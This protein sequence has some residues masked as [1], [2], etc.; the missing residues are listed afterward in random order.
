MRI[1]RPSKKTV[2]PR[3]ASKPGAQLLDPRA[4][5]SAVG[6]RAI[7]QELRGEG[8]PLP[9]STRARMEGEL[10]G[11]F[12]DVR[13]HTGPEAGQQARAEG[14][15][16]FTTGTDIVF[17]RGEYRPGTPYGDALIAH[18]LAHVMQ[19]RGATTAGHESTALEADASKAAARTLGGMF[20][21]LRTRLAGLGPVLRSGLTVQRCSCGG[22]QK[23]GAKTAPA[24]AAG[25]AK[26]DDKAVKTQGAPAD[27][28]VGEK[29][30]LSKA[31]GFSRVADGDVKWTAAELA[32]AKRLLGKIPPDAKAAIQGVALIRVGTPN[33]PGGDP[34]GCFRASV[35]ST[36]GEREDVIELGNGAFSN[37]KDF[38]EPEKGKGKSEVKSY[39]TDAS[40]AKINSL[41][42]EDVLAH[43]IGHAV[44]SAAQREAEAERFKAD[45]AVTPKHDA[46]SK[47]AGR[48][49]NPPVAG[50]SNA[51]AAEL[52]YHGK[53]IVTNKAIESVVDEVQKVS[54]EVSAKK[55]AESAKSIK[56]LKPGVQKAIAL[57]KAAKAKLPAG[58]S[59]PQTS[60]ESGQDAAL[61]AIDDIVKA[62]E[63]KVE[64]QKELEK[65]EKAEAAS[66]GKVPGS[67]GKVDTSR[68]LAEI[69]AIVRLKKIDVK[70]S[71]AIGKYP[72]DNWPDHPEELYADLFQMSI[73]EPGGLK[74]FDPDIAAYFEQPIGIKNAGLKK[75]VDEWVEKQK[76]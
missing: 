17:D 37:D 10:G 47:L 1:R 9:A 3:A 14:A 33:C 6:N 65:G 30:A 12:K 13:I 7:E 46:L 28:L 61:A 71:D 72:K 36:T 51:V 55:L 75:R 73:S 11:S 4:L 58:S 67:V 27:P 18:E 43:E 22:A 52:T 69:V 54:G 59:A 40:G 25:K 53:L 29:A 48:F 20:S 8:Q 23:A 39:R 5:S 41:P 24:K 26:S 70:N 19:Q 63:A 62:I 34:A 45:L 35:N 16:A 60:V 74:V 49:N 32:K 66:K 57:R 76:K 2:D 64:A 15:S 38:E 56:K 21:G 68:R 31:Y 44:D 50:I 42:S